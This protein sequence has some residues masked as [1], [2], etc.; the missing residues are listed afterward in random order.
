MAASAEGRAKDRHNYEMALDRLR[1]QFVFVTLTTP[2]VP[3]AGLPA[4]IDRFNLAFKKLTKRKEILALSEGYV[5]KLELTY[6]AE[7]NDYNPHFH[8]IFAVNKSYFTSRAYLKQ[9]RWLEIWREVT[10]DD[11]ITQVHV[12]KLKDADGKGAAE[13]AAYAAKDAEYLQNDNVFKVFYTALKGR[14]VLTYNG[15]FA[16]GNKLFK[17]T[18][19]TD[20]AKRIRPSTYTAFCTAGAGRIRRSRAQRTDRGRKAGAQQAA[21]RGRGGGRMNRAEAVRHAIHEMELAGLEFTADELAMWDKIASGELPLEYAR[22][23]ADR[24]LA[25]MRKR[26]PEKF[27]DYEPGK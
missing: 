12:Q 5:R 26:F 4:E 18:S 17:S 1:K 2:N 27:D 3:A 16:D 11:S 13:M 10:G 21:D 24:Q 23:E 7:R 19:W 15:L 22:E 20:S 9:A 8:V 14:Q 6:N 25:E